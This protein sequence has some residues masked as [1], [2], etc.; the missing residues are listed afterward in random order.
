[1]C[2]YNFYL[3]YK[4][5]RRP[6]WSQI[7]IIFWPCLHFVINDIESETSKFPEWEFRGKWSRTPFVLVKRGP[8]WDALNQL[9]LHYW[10]ESDRDEDEGEEGFVN[11][12]SVTHSAGLLRT[13]SLSTGPRSMASLFKC[14]RVFVSRRYLDNLQRRDEQ[15]S[16]QGQ[17]RGQCP[18][19]TV[20]L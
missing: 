9:F 17:D 20:S 14:Q 8:S 19:L 5:K 10:W 7:K 1:M 13:R 4:Q 12:C 16:E 15:D 18:T 2:W 3:H 6:S 11:A